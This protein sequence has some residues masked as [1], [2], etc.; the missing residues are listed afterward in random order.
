M[1]SLVKLQNSLII[2]LIL[3][4]ATD[5]QLIIKDFRH[6]YLV[7]VALEQALVQHNKRKTRNYILTISYFWIASIKELVTH[8][9]AN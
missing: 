2:T 4:M 7:S 8:G 5:E 6:Y 1:L 3:L 9:L